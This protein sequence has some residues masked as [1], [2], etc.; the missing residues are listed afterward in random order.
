MSKRRNIVIVMIILILINY[1]FY[2]LIFSSPTTLD[3]GGEF[4]QDS[5]DN[6]D[7]VYDIYNLIT[8]GSGYSMLLSK[9][10]LSDLWLST[11]DM[12]H[13]LLWEEDLGP[14][15]DYTPSIFSTEEYI[16]VIDR[17]GSIMASSETQ[18]TNGTSSLYQYVDYRDPRVLVFDT[19]GDLVSNFSIQVCNVTSDDIAN[20]ITKIPLLQTMSISSDT[21]Y[22]VEYLDVLYLNLT[23]TAC[24]FLHS[25]DLL[26]GEL[27]WHDRITGFCFTEENLQHF[28]IIDRFDLEENKLML[29]LKSSHLD[30]I[31][32]HKY[33][34]TFDSDGITDV[35]EEINTYSCQDGCT[36]DLILS[37][38]EM[39]GVSSEI[40]GDE[41]IY[42]FISTKGYELELTTAEWSY[43]GYLDNQYS[44]M[45]ILESYLIDSE[46][47]TLSGTISISP[48]EY[49]FY[50]GILTSDDGLELNLIDMNNSH[51]YYVSSVDADSILS[52]IHN[53]D[54]RDK[55]VVLWSLSRID[56][57]NWLNPYPKHILPLLLIILAIILC[58]KKTDEK[59]RVETRYDIYSPSKNAELATEHNTN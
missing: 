37:F 1:A 9:T 17:F 8:S 53:A 47:I 36:D 42:S 31:D 20:N 38:D 5:S 50:F 14:F 32:L 58:M 55:T 46:T 6:L 11:Y 22:I 28:K 4:A 41:R 43:S 48:D 45:R 33:I 56:I 16:S 12:D 23:G 19:S 44:G 52:I 7:G 51:V 59:K 54:C 40:D 49:K 34:I 2:P 39:I 24:I 27:N 3:M 25:Y 13:D 10:A 15:E 30:N 35:E 21:I 29:M 26:T 57:V 18:H